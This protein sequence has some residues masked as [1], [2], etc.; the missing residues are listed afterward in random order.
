MK[1]NYAL[2]N[3]H[4]GAIS[5]LV[6]KSNKMLKSTLRKDTEIMEKLIQEAH[7]INIPVIKYN[8]EIS[9]AC[10][11]TLVYLYAR[12]K[13]KIAREMPAGVG[14]T[15]F[16]FYQNSNC[17]YFEKNISSFG[18]IS[19]WFKKSNIATYILK[20]FQINQIIPK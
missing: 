15:D 7:D 18:C 16:I 2:K 4:M 20:F 1:F 17:N 12:S 9:L 13:Y 5:K 11:I 3:H 6:L 14:F 8:D 10:I 19:F